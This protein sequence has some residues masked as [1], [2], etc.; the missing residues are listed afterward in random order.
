MADAGREVEVED[1]AAA[2]ARAWAGGDPAD[3]AHRAACA[4]R[5]EALRHRFREAPGLFGPAAVD[6]L[7]AVADALRSAPPPAGRP[8]P[9]ALLRDVFGHAAFRPGQ[10]EIV[11]AVLAGRDCVGVMPTGAGKSLTY[12]IPARLLGGTTL[13]VSPLIALMKDQVDAMA[14]VGLRA[15][16]LNSSLSA[17]ERRARVERLRRGEL[18]LVYAAPEGLEASVGAAL[19]GVP[20]ALIAVD[21]AHCISHWGHDFRPAYRNLAG[22]KDRF[23]APVLA[24]TATATREV[25]RD[26]A[27][28]LG[29][30]EPLLVR[31]SFFRRNLRIHA[32]KKGER[33]RGRDAILRLVRARRGESG[34]VYAM[35]RKAVEDTAESLRRHGVRAAAY[36]AGLDAETRTRVQDAFQADAVDVVVAT[37]AF[38]MGIDKPDIRFVVH[39]DLPRSIEAYYQEIGRAG[40][41]GA[42]SDCVLLYS[43]ADVLSWDRMLE[44]ADA[45]VAAWQRRQ[46]RTMFRFADGEGCRH[47][48]LVGYF[49]EAID[50]CRDACDRCGGAG[51]LDARA[52]APAREPS[53]RTRAPRRRGD[54]PVEGAAAGEGAPDPGIVAALRALRTRLARARGVPAF[55]IFSDATLAAIAAAR[56]GT[57]EELIALKGIGPRKLAEHG[58]AILAAVGGGSQGQVDE[59]AP[60]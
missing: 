55:V 5:L 56:P 14:R 4:A 21:E 6:R 18:E 47:E 52:A 31:G 23:R 41:D 33:L 59:P 16:F 7:R 9:R 13:V 44:E 58:D 26:I 57:P 24:L 40:R 28:Q 34:I 54:L 25:T 36:H 32:L 10:E 46:V 3:A 20:L 37:V 17:D 8:T 1:E 22:L 2:L 49:G 30:R 39:R 19:G 51:V 27:A 29:M 43:W 38:G 42:P 53:R 12:Q 15:T 60:E 11:S 35:S 50:A 45:D 48:R